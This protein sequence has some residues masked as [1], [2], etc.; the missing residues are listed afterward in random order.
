MAARFR[1]AGV[2]IKLEAESS[3]QGGFDPLTLGN[4]TRSTAPVADKCW[5]LDDV[6][7]GVDHEARS[8]L[9]D[10]FD[11]FDPNNWLFFP[12]GKIEVSN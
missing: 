1:A 5:V 9:V 3:T 12:G 10:N 11:S 8:S 6:A 4:N 2:C 7:L